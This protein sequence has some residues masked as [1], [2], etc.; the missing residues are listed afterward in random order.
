[1]PVKLHIPELAGDVWEIKSASGVTALLAPDKGAWA[2]SCHVPTQKH[3]LVNLLHTDF[4]EIAGYPAKIRGGSPVLFPFPSWVSFRGQKDTYESGGDLYQLP[5]HGFLR[6]KNFQL[7]DESTGDSRLLAQFASD[8]HTRD[9]YPFDFLAQMSFEVTANGL[10]SKACITNTSPVT[11]PVAFGFHPYLNLHLTAQSVREK[12]F[13]EMPYCTEISADD[14]EWLKYSARPLDD[15]HPSIDQDFSGTRY[16]NQCAYNFMRLV[17]PVSGLAI[18]VEWRFQTQRQYVAL[19]AP[20]QQSP[21]FCIE[22]W[23]NLPNSYGRPTELALLASG[24]QATFELI[25]SLEEL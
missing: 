24:E 9:V 15:D 22:P 8:A 7:A 10:S 1:M 17:D 14:N 5:Q 4:Q 6:K 18:K 3:G 12:F 19:W 23:S 25:L 13:V 21:Y 2:L 16:F 11:S 20:D